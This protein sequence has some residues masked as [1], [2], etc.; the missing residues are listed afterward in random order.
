MRFAI[1]YSLVV[2][3]IEFFHT[4]KCVEDFNRDV[5]YRGQSLQ[6]MNSSLVRQR[7]I[8]YFGEIE[9]SFEIK[10]NGPCEYYKIKGSKAVMGFISGSSKYFCDKCNRVRLDCAGRLLLCLFSG[11]SYEL[12]QMMRNGCR[13]EEIAGYIKDIFRMKSMYNK[14]KVIQGAKFEMSNIGG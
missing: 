3:F 11:Y 1:R 10:G 13:D 4:G 6:M 14:K 8:D 2:R 7:L 5:P 12:R 9:Q